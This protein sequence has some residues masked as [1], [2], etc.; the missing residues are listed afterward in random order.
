[1]AL[2]SMRVSAVHSTAL[3]FAGLVTGC[4]NAQSVQFAPSTGQTATNAH[5]RNSQSWMAADAVSS[6]LLYVSD[7]GTAK[8]YVYSYPQLKLEGTLKGFGE[9]QGLCTDEAGDVFVTDREASQTIEFAHGGTTRVATLGI[10]QYG[11]VGCSV[12]PKTGDLAVSELS[13]PGSN[14]LNP[15][16]A[17]AIYKQAKGRP[18]LYRQ[19]N[20]LLNIF[21]CGYDNAGN[22]LVDGWKPNGQ[23]GLSEISA[24]H[25]DRSTD[26]I[27]NGPLITYPDYPGSIQ[28]DGTHW[29]IGNQGTGPASGESSVYALQIKGQS[30]TVVGA[31]PLSASSDMVQ[32]WIVGSGSH[33]KL[34]APDFVKGDVVVY[35][36]GARRGTV[37]KVITGGFSEP[38]GSTVSKKQ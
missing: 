27:W 18:K 4:S 17:I 36:Y 34:I 10:P 7:A 16:A 15:N 28:W 12:D 11:P 20:F 22:L 9:P 21:F 30:S 37:F 23:F 31:N 29:V 19:L 8:V 14:A 13:G 2:R 33:A 6:D 38:F 3:V 26:I 5:A 1:M 32:F 25:P 24:E 35:D